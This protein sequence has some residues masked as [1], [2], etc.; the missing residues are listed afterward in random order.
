[1]EEDVEL[2]FVG[3]ADRDSTDGAFEI[4]GLDI[5]FLFEPERIEEERA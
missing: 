1:M 2:A 3:T 5:E 4:E